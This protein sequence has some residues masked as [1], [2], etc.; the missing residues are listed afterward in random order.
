M[1][2]FAAVSFRRAPFEV[3][4]GSRVWQVP[5][6]DAGQWMDLL[7]YPDWTVRLFWLLD[8]GA[9]E[10][11]QAQAQAGDAAPEELTGAMCAALESAS[12]RR[13][14]EALRIAQMCR[15]TPNLVGALFLRGLDPERMTLAALLATAWML[16]TQN[17]SD[18]QRTQLEMELTMPPPGV[19]LETDEPTMEDLVARMRNVPGMSIG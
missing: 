5:Y 6:L 12:G 15:S 13:W 11:F 14:W 7:S 4:H 19:G 8:P 18:I 16:A 3:E 17:A 2:D 9:Q 1:A 10:D